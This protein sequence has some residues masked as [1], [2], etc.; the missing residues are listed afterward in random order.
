MVLHHSHGLRAHVVVLAPE[1]RWGLLQ[2]A[3]LAA[4][5]EGVLVEVHE[6]RRVERLRRALARQRDAARLQVLLLRLERLRRRRRRR[7]TLVV[8]RQHLRL[9]LRLHVQQRLHRRRRRHGQASGGAVGAHRVRAMRAGGRDGVLTR[10]R[11]GGGG[12][13]GAGQG[14]QVRLRGRVHRVPPLGGGGGVVRCEGVQPLAPPAL[15][16]PQRLA[17][18]PRD[19]PGHPP[20]R[21]L[22]AAL[23]GRTPPVEWRQAAPHARG[24]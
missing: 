18:V 21:V 7:V 2:D 14:A 6:V 24:R 19:P 3:Q 1:G 11:R 10:S 20:L 12:G 16:P 13:A 23:L 4:A 15:R 17:A 22:R 5:A 9:H 8:H